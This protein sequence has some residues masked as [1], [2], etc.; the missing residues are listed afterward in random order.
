MKYLL[1]SLLL[2]GCAEPFDI[3][4]VKAEAKHA[5]Y[6]HKVVAVTN[7]NVT[8]FTVQEIPGK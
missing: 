6:R 3:S 4:R 1:I 2:V 8:E 5:I 7:G